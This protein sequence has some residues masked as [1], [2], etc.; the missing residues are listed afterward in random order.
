MIKNIFKISCLLMALGIVLGAFAAHGL[1]G[2]ISSD[3]LL[4][5]ETGVK[6]HLLHALAL[7]VLSFNANYFIEKRFKISVML[8]LLGIF[9]FSGSL[10]FLSTLELSGMDSLKSAIGPITP[11]G[12]LFFI[13]GWLMLAFSMKSSK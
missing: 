5:F 13:S 12:G 11:A 1:K 10:Y 2:K 7:M 6:Y 4:I 9:F 3:K 8:L